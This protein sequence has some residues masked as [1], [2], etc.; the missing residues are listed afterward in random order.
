MPS[1]GGSRTSTSSLLGSGPGPLPALIT[2]TRQRTGRAADPAA[3][4]TPGV[5][6]E[7]WSDAVPLGERLRVRLTQADPA[8]ARI[9]FAPA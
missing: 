5:H 1:D 8:P 3:K 6:T 4:P 9:R 7:P 2:A